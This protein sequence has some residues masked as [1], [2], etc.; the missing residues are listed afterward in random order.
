MALGSSTFSNFGGAVGDIFAGIGADI[1]AKGDELEATNYRLAAQYA[2]KEAT[3]SE[4]STA[5]K[6]YQEGREIYG[7]IS[8]QKADVGAAGFGASGSAL[9]LLRDSAQQGAL[10]QAVLGEQG[11]ITEEGYKEQAQSYTNMAQAADLAAKG[12]KTAA[13]GDYIAGGFK[14]AA[15]VAT[16]AL[17]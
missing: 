7:A 1:K 13:I 17:A 8:E 10:T 2:D 14:A 16:L 15:G 12:E 11:L 6:Q 9:D 3:Y 4:W 5:I